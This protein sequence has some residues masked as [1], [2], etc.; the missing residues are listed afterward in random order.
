[1]CD[2]KLNDIIKQN[3]T[4]EAILNK[5]IGV[6]VDALTTTVN[7]LNI[8]LQETDTKKL[9]ATLTKGIKGLMTTLQKKEA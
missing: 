3:N 1:M 5:Q 9:N 8:K 2:N 6:V 7:T 4:V